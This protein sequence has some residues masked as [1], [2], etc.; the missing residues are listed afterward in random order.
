MNKRKGKSSLCRD[1]SLKL[2]NI[3]TTVRTDDG[4]V[5]F[6][7]IDDPV[8]EKNSIGFGQTIYEEGSEIPPIPGEYSEKTELYS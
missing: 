6:G 1:P 5:Y 8:L 4:D 3:F 2:K 7:K